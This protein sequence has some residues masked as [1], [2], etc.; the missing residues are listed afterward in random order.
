M[1]AIAWI[2]AACLIEG[3]VIAPGG[4]PVSQMQV[5]AAETDSVLATTG[6]GGSFT[7]AVPDSLSLVEA[8]G[9]ALEFRSPDFFPVVQRVKCGSRSVRIQVF[10]RVF[11]LPVVNVR[12]SRL[13]TQPEKSP[14]R[15][16]QL[17]EDFVRE[18]AASS[19]SLAE[20]AQQLPGVGA[21]GRDGYTSAPTIRGMGRGRSLLLL[22]GMR[23]SADRG[24]G[25]AGNFLDPFLVRSL[26][27]VRGASGVA[28]GSGAIGG[29]LDVG[30]GAVDSVFTARSRFGFTSNGNGREFAQWVAGRAR[31][32]WRVGAG[33]FYHTTDDYEFPEGE[34]AGVTSPGGDAT[35]SGFENAGGVGVCETDVAGGTLRFVGLGTS[36][37]EIGRPTTQP[38]RLDT[39]ETEDHAFGTLRYLRQREEGRLECGLGFHRPRTVNRGERFLADGSRQRTGWTE[40]ASYDGTATLLLERGAGSGRWLAGS[41]VFVRSN[42]IA[43]ETTVYYSSGVAGDPVLVDLVTG[44][45]RADGGVFAGW[46]QPVGHDGRLV[47]AGRLDYARREADGRKTSSWVSPSLTLGAVLPLNPSFALTGNLARSFRAPRIQELYFEGERPGGM[48]LANPDLEPET[49][50]SLEGGV[51]WRRQEWEASAT[52]WGMLASDLIVQLPVDAAGDTLRHENETEGRLLG[53][54][55]GGTWRAPGGRG[56]VE[57]AY[58]FVY[59]EDEGGTP[60]PDIPSAVVRVTSHWRVWGRDRGRSATA[61][62]ALR[63]GAAKTPPAGGADERWWSGLLGPTDVGGDEVGHPGFARWDAGLRLVLARCVSLDFEGSNL[64]DSR[65]IDRP[66]SDAFPQPGRSFQMALVLGVGGETPAF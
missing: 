62:V 19:P 17:D 27:V 60:L 16:D 54:E 41:D 51:R 31:P 33:G 39:I 3:Q 52:I 15:I 61:R 24:V 66:E 35:N 45:L 5:I 56:R 59:G 49:A 36:A 32:G 58:A 50:W 38:R 14:V 42:V 1:T 18:A 8:D 22:E 63:A 23:I 43:N 34:E 10:P 64:L 37:D 55:I 20:A 9:L 4:A 28:Y 26:D 46:K 53:C 6:P 21:V 13:E 65:Y 29:V 11:A 2:L 30:L 47:A 57:L 48:R 12:A 40:N 25:P 44:G 7:I